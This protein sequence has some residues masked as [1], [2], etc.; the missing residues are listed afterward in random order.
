MIFIS[1][2]LFGF[3]F[4]LQYLDF[5]QVAI[6]SAISTITSNLFEIPTGAISDV[7]GRKW[8]LFWSFALSTLG[9][10][11]VANGQTFMIFAIG[12]I[13][14][15]FAS[16]LFSGTHESLLYDSLKSTHQENQFD[17]V[18]ATAE[19]YSWVGLFIAALA[20]GILYD[21]WDVGPYLLTSFVY[22]LTALLCLFLDEPTVDSET[23]SISAYKEQN[24]KGFHELFQDSKTTRISLL[25]I[26]LTA[27]YFFASKI[28][29][30]AQAEEY[31]MSGSGIGLLFGAGYI[32]A[33]L[34]SHFYPTLRRRFGNKQLLMAA[35]AILLASFIFAPFVGLTLGS[36]L[37]IARIASSTTFGNAKSVVMNRFISSKNRARIIQR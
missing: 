6:I 27:G 10:L 11:I 34:S 20:G 3:L 8:T 5:T 31:G 29:G 28:L 26:T 25:M 7:I 33:A 35:T 22:A 32:I 21:L 14:S 18:I 1:Q 23:F 17:I 36:L 37:I 30:I 9:L 19:K 24:L 13:I 4:F 15:G 16:A 12:R 2:L